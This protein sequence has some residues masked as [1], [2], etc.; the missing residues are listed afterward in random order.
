[1]I[2]FDSVAGLKRLLT[3]MTMR[4]CGEYLPPLCLIIASV[5][6]LLLG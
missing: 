1:M 6:K 2:G 5:K 3:K 4:G